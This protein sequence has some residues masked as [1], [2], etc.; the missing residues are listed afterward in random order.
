VKAHLFVG[1]LAVAIALLV[2]LQGAT[3][4]YV[5]SIER[6]ITRLETLAEVQRLEPKRQALPAARIVDQVRRYDRLEAA[7]GLRGLDLPDDVVVAHV[8]GKAPRRGRDPRHREHPRE[9]LGQ[10]DRDLA[11]EVGLRAHG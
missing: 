1:I 8:P 2:P 9:H 3:L 4:A 5:V 11:E 6:R 10:C 7:V